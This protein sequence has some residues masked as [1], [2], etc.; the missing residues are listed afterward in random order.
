MQNIKKNLIVRAW[1][2]KNGYLT[3]KDV[4]NMYVN[5]NCVSKKIEIFLKF[6]TPCVLTQIDI[7]QC[8]AKV[9]SK[10][11]VYN[12]PN[13]TCNWYSTCNSTGKTPWVKVV[14]KKQPR[15]LN[16]PSHMAKS[17]DLTLQL[18]HQEFATT[19]W[20]SKTYLVN[21]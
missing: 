18:H 9:A 14:S 1:Q 4:Q 17:I 12:L 6:I 13:L 15:I 16:F 20:N 11:L 19:I 5:K 3:V 8:N 2:I 7:H 21:G 10:A